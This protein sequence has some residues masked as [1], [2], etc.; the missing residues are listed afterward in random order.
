MGSIS[1]AVRGVRDSI[2]AGYILGRKPGSSSGA[3]QLL[4]LSDLHAIG[5]ATHQYVQQSAGTPNVQT[6]LDQLGTTRGS[7]TY[8]GASAWVLLTPGSAGQIVQSNGAGADPTYFTP[9]WN[10][11]TGANL[12]Y[13]GPGSGSP[14][15]PTFRS[16][17]PADLPVFSSTQAGAVP[18]SG[19]GTTKFL[20]ADGTWVAPTGGS[21]TV[22]SVAMT[23]PSQFSVLGTPITTSGTL[24]LQW[25]LQLANT[26]LMGPVSGGAAAPTFRNIGD[27]DLSALSSA[28]LTATSRSPNT[29]LAGPASGGSGASSFRALVA[30]DLPAVYR[31]VLQSSTT[32][33]VNPST[34]NDSNP[35]T[36]GSPFL[37][38]AHAVAVAT[39]YDTNSLSHTIQLQNGT[40]ALTSTVFLP[41][42]L[43]GGN[44][45]ILGNA[46]SPASV[47][48]SAASNIGSVIATLQGATGAWHLSSFTISAATTTF[49]ISASS[50]GASVGV[51]GVVF[52]AAVTAHAVASFDGNIQLSGN[53]ITGGAGVHAYAP[54]GGIIL[55]NSGTYTLTGTPAFSNSFVYAT[56]LGLIYV[57]AAPTF[58]GSATG[59]TY[60]AIYNAVIE[61][62]GV[63][64][65]GNAAGTTGTGGQVH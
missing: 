51:T 22:T 31:Q 41:T 54:Q 48:I 25:N 44:I 60:T 29:V 26:V 24:G 10:T 34:G 11:A 50:A 52:G 45:T 38:I 21:G 43:G 16:L 8:R 64:F 33:Y 9:I 15:S 59:S 36:S 19:G 40:Y 3:A 65:P 35:G 1:K 58:S 63:T 14:A 27:S 4:S 37:T 62:N 23:A 5:V 42:I 32:W 61:T 30:A 28:V 17:V 56:Q 47:T 2:P 6:I 13:A 49:H 18:A 55:F 57:S 39:S 53:T 46:G 7:L 20:R 12:V